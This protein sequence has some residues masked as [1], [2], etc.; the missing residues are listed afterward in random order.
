MGVDLYAFDFLCKYR[1]QIRGDALCLGRQNFNI[2]DDGAL[3]RQVLARYDSQAVLADLAKGDGYSETLLRYLGA[4][5]VVAMDISAFEGASV[6]QDLNEPVP[7]S[8]CDRF[9]FILDGGTLEH[10][11]DFPRAILNVKRMLRPG[12]LFISINAANNQLFHGMYQ[13]GP[14]LFWRVFA[15]GSG[16]CIDRMQLIGLTG[17]LPAPIDLVDPNGVR[18]HEGPTQTAMYLAVAVRR[19][20]NDAVSAGKVYQSDYAAA[21]KA[22]S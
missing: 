6:I 4:A 20:S 5:T 2:S 1:G 19:I 21:W 14:E 12:G 8:L 11:F 22:R 3:A 9:N 13:F 18:P 7:D 15:P 10:I 16:F 17:N